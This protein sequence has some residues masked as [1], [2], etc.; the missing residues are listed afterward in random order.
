MARHLTLADV[1]TS[2]LPQAV[3]LCAGDFPAIAAIVNSATQR[4]LFARESGDE[5]WWGTWAEIAFDLTQAD[6]FFTAPRD[7]ARIEALD[8]CTYP[9]PI[10][11]QFFEYLRFGFGRWPKSTCATDRCAPLQAYSRGTVPTFKDIAPPDKKV[12]SYLTDPAD[13][14]KRVLIQGKDAN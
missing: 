6:P 1:A 14:G 7:V 10:Q 4:I 13:V 2:R 5:G 8:V 9:I 11:N 3:G 12:R